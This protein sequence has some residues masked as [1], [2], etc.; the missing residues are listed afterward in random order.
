MNCV[1]IELREPVSPCILRRLKPT[2]DEDEGV[3]LIL[4][5][6]AIKTDAEVGDGGWERRKCNRMARKQGRGMRKG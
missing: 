3:I 4:I 1:R 6:E 5:I 2:T